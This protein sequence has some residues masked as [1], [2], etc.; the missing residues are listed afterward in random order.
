MLQKVGAPLTLLPV[1]INLGLEQIIQYYS[2]ATLHQVILQPVTST[3]MVTTTTG[4]LLLQ[5]MG[6]M[7]LVTAE[8]LPHQ[9]TSAHMVGVYLQALQVANTMP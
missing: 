6:N 8:A 4:I 5:A 9:A 1:M 2:L 3:P 7:V